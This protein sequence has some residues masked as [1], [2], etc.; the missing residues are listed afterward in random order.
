MVPV[1][2]AYEKTTIC[3]GFH[4]ASRTRTGDLLGAIQI[5]ASEGTSRL[6]VAIHGK[7]SSFAGILSMMSETPFTALYSESR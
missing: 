4:R 5:R 3:G 1:T 2:V 6:F 7:K